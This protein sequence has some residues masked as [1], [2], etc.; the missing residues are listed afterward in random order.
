MAGSDK[1]MTKKLL[2]RSY[3]LIL[4]NT[5][6][7]TKCLVPELQLHLLDKSCPWYHKTEVPELKYDPF[8]SVFWPGG[9]VLSRFVFDNK[10][11]VKDKMVMDIGC[12]C[13]ALGIAAKK[14]GATT[15]LCNDI[16]RVAMAAVQLN[17][18]LNKLKPPILSVEDILSSSCTIQDQNTA[19][20]LGDMFYDEAMAKKIVAWCCRNSRTGNDIFIGDPGRWGLDFIRDHI[21]KVAEYDIHDDDCGEYRAA[22]VF[23]FIPD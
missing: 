20:F 19:I 3:E 12:G 18:Q 23:R 8:W 5:K 15:V 2:Q 1:L 6:V 14:A 22:S 13:G 9:Q 21:S 11:V 16:D 4:K 7:G 17:F 10:T